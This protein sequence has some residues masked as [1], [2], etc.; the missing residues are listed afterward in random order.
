MSTRPPVSPWPETNL[1]S[2]PRIRELER[3]LDAELQA[4]TARRN[5]ATA[6]VAGVTSVHNHYANQT[7][8]VAVSVD[9]DTYTIDPVE[10]GAQWIQLPPVPGTAASLRYETVRNLRRL[11]DAEKAKEGIPVDD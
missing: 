11:I 1:R 4:Q 10:P 9:G 6:K 3:Q 5:A 2:T 8:V 7:N